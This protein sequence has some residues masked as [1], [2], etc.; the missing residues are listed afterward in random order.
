MIVLVPIAHL[1]PAVLVFI[2]PLVTLAPATLPRL[3]QFAA[4]VVCLLAPASMTIDGFVQFML[5]MHDTALAP[6]GTFRMK[7]WHC[8]EEEHRCEKAR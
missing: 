4:L 6:V 5:R 3:V 7:A 1:V 8:G 2:P